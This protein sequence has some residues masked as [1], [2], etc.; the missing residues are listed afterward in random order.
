MRKKKIKQKTKKVG[1]FEPATFDFVAQHSN[2]S[3]IQPLCCQKENLPYLYF[4]AKKSAQMWRMRRRMRK[5]CAF[6]GAIAPIAPKFAQTCV[7]APKKI[8]TLR[9]V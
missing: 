1:G 7:P 2:H 5:I 9:L 6:F 3:A 8:T 4:T